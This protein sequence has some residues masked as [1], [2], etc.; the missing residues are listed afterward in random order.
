M[1]L[2]G[3][4]LMNLLGGTLGGMAQKVAQKVIDR[5]LVVAAIT[6]ATAALMTLF[7]TTVAPMAAAMFETQYGQFIGLA[8]PP[9]A[10]SCLAAISLVWVG[11]NTYKLVERTVLV[12]G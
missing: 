9:V 10:G 2:L 12:N 7:N 5:G 6:A 8:F 3:Q 1:P 4:L 11:C